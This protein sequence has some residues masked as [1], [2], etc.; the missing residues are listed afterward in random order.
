MSFRNRDAVEDWKN[1]MMICDD[2]KN[3][4]TIHQP[5]FLA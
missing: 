4:G 1:D 3:S 5:P 2:G